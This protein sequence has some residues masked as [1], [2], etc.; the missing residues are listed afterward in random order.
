MRFK[1]TQAEKTECTPLHTP[2]LPS[3]LSCSG[4]RCR[5]CV[6]ERKKYESDCEFVSVVVLFK[7]SAMMGMNKEKKK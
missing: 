2:D 6:R 1:H 5:L 3:R 7:Q 4:A